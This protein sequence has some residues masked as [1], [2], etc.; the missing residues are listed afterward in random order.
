MKILGFEI[1]RAKAPVR[2]KKSFSAAN[3]GN[4][5]A[6]WIPSNNTADVDIKRDLKSIRNR[7]RELMR[8]D[9]Y[10]KKFKR[11]I[12]SNVV[13][14]QG[15]KLQNQAKDTNGNLDKKA[16]KTI[17]TAYKKWGK[18]GNCDVTGKY[19]LID[20][21]KMIMGT[22]AEDGEVLVRK[23]KGFDNECGFALQLLEADHLDEQFTD[24]NR[25]ILMGIE[26]DKWNKPI[27]YHLHKT[28]PG[29]ST[30]TSRD[31]TRERIPADEINH[32]FLPLR[33]SATRGVP[34]MASA[35]TRMKMINGYEEAELV[36]ARLGAS[37]AGFYTRNQA[38]GEYAG[39]SE[40]NGTPINEVTPGEFEVLPE[41]WGF[42][43]YDP[44]HPNAAFKDF[45]KVVLRGVASGLDVS[46]NSLANDLEGV[47]FSSLRSGI[48]EEREVWKDLQKWLTEH[49]LDDVFAD[50]L[51]M[52]LLTQS[53]ALP[54]FKIDKFIAPT[55]M[56][57][58][59]DW[60]DPL[61]DV[62]ANILA[63]KE[64]L[65]THSQL[66]AEMGMDIEEL[67]E[68]LAYEKDLREKY[69]ITL[70]SD[71]ELGNIIESK[72]ED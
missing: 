54:Y 68:Q 69:G 23:V 37:K 12:K 29:N 4:L 10:A 25:N 43:A 24:T 46:Y 7:S 33:I 50:W 71:V 9:D 70:M 13:G 5:Y 59:F 67:Y 49:L 1:K 14:S 22:L 72:D 62:Q 53:V 36:G 2:Q 15:I 51:D 28:H 35:M 57:R 3:T 56:P 39:D 45:M 34:W 58:K 20:I 42:E 21:K 16:N 30:L 11:M 17:E 41:G 40:V 48:I 61:K 47:N 66:A 65:K 27:A 44:Q 52:A 55:W 32:L 38:E 31:I 6:S 8:N 60:I 26:Y 19:S 63:I 18:K 64:G